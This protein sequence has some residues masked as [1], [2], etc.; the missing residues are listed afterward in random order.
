MCVRYLFYFVVMCE[1]NLFSL[2]NQLVID[3]LLTTEVD[4]RG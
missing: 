2:E 3:T 4:R 1:L